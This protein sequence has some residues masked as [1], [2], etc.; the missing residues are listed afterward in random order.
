MFKKEKDNAIINKFDKSYLLVQ[1]SKSLVL[2]FSQVKLKG[3]AFTL[4]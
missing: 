2:N 4:S 1:V 3:H